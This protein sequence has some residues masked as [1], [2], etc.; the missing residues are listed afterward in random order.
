MMEKD[1]SFYI[2]GL[3]EGD[4]HIVIACEKTKSC[5]FAITFKKQNLPLVEYLKSYIGHGFLRNK[6]KENAVVLT[7]SSQ[8]GLFRIVD[9]LNGKLRTPKIFKFNLLIDWLN[10]KFNQSINKLNL[11]TSLITENYWFA[12]FCEANACFDIRISQLQQK[13][14]IAFRWR[15]DQRMFDPTT[16][17]SYKNC[18][19][20]IACS[21]NAKLKQIDRKHGS[22]Y[23][24]SIT[25]FDGLFKIISYFKEFNLLGVKLLDFN[26]WVKAFNIYQNRHK[27]TLDLIKELKNIKNQMNSRRTDFFLSHFNK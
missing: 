25:K 18:L 20:L 17:Q 3:W 24:I 11:D 8:K 1:I 6:V 4:G 9:L 7:I 16:K 23:H 22:Y 26:L 21:F 10:L 2:A 5:S 12:G 13:S 27:I 19:S 15:L 14:H